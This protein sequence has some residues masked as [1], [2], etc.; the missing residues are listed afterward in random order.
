MA[1][2]SMSDIVPLLVPKPD[3]MGLRFS[4]GIVRQWNPQTFENII[5]WRG[6]SLPDVPVLSSV[7][8]L[9]FQVGNV[10]GMLGWAPEGGTSSWWILGRMSIPGQVPLF[11]F[12]ADF[13]VDGFIKSAS[14]RPLE[15]SNGSNVS[16]TST[17]FV[18]PTAGAAHT[19]VAPPSGVVRVDVSSEFVVEHTSGAAVARAFGAFQ[20]REG[21]LIGF[22]PIIHAATIDESVIVGVETAAGGDRVTGGATRAK[23]ITNLDPGITYNIEYRHR[24]AG[25][26]IF[27]DLHRV[28]MTTPQM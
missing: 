28:V 26:G 21:D 18:A 2:N 14:M 13:V 11:V 19:F 12:D 24:V 1:A 4:Q 25:T 9:G 3:T 15:S 16:V 27:Q 17:T 22:G 23:L 10:V 7:D 5:E 8:A 20:V 6:I